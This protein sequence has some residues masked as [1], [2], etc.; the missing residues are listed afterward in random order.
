[1]Y[2]NNFN[3]K[4]KRL[5]NFFTKQNMKIKIKRAKFNF[6]VNFRFKKLNIF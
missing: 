5:L 4:L 3:Y 1:M 6:L 2:I